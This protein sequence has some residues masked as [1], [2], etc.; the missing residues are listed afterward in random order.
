[1]NEKFTPE[2]WERIGKSCIRVSPAD[3]HVRGFGSL[4]IAEFDY[5]N[6]GKEEAFANACLVEAAP[7]MYKA[8]KELVEVCH[9]IIN[10][11]ANAHPTPESIIKTMEPILKKARGEVSSEF[12]QHKPDRENN[13]IEQQELF[14][15]D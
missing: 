3:D 5:R 13:S 11:Y 7:K 6:F 1:M 12:L 9:N 14:R 8:M 4:L 15:C 10:N 2:R